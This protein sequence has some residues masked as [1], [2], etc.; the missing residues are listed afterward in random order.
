MH[1]CLYDVS[2]SEMV[3]LYKPYNEKPTRD[4]SSLNGFLLTISVHQFSVLKKSHEK[5]RHLPTLPLAQGF[6]QLAITQIAEFHLKW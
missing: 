2:Y 4:L 1:T 3:Y 6:L 5:Y